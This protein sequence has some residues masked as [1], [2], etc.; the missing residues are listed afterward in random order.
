MKENLTKSTHLDDDLSLSNKNVKEKLNKSLPNLSHEVIL[1]KTIYQLKIILIGDSSVG[2]TSL[3]NRYMGY[4][5]IENQP[6]TVNTD[7][8]VKSISVSAEIGTE[9]TIWDTCGQERYRSMTRAYFKDA[10]GIVLVYDVGKMESFD[11]LSGWM[12]DIKNNSNL[13]PAIILVANKIDLDDRKIS[14]E[15]GMKYAEKNGLMYVETSSKEGINIDSP[16]E[17]LANTLIK[18]IKEN[19]N[20]NINAVNKKLDNHGE[21]ENFEKQR[22][23]EVKCC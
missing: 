7:F 15:T 21:K 10:H 5:F 12:K 17:K 23:K 6:C 14:K 22:E 1:S 3:V 13:D 2:K 4:E 19:P 20:Y 16:F 18:K 11:N 8:K 9:L